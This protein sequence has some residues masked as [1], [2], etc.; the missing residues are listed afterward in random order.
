MSDQHPPLTPFPAAPP[1][2]PG[3]LPVAQ[4]VSKWPTVFG[5]IGIIVG[6]LGALGA[7]W[8]II[9]SFALPQMMQE[10]PALSAASL[11]KLQR[12]TIINST[13]GL[14]VAVLLLVSAIG[15]VTRRRWSVSASKAWAVLRILVGILSTALGLWMQEAFMEASPAMA[16][17][18]SGLIRGM[19]VF[20]AILGIAW[21]CTLPVFALIWFSRA[22]IKTEVAA[23]R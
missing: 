18:S 3:L 12:L 20:G 15:L 2:Q 10:A 17:V 23:W 9:S 6:V 14:P 11:E 8:G 22:K 4:A 13:M 19:Q 16:G 7:A 1:T 21:S 5:V